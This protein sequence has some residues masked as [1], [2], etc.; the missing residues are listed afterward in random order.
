MADLM[1]S[2]P[3]ESRLTRMVAAGQ[4]IEKGIQKRL[5]TFVGLVGQMVMPLVK[6]ESHSGEEDRG[7]DGEAHPE[8]DVFSGEEVG[9]DK[10]G[11]CFFSG[12]EGGD[13]ETDIRSGDD[14]PDNGDEH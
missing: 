3:G 5:R 8:P 11:S 2:L 7:G 1:E 9:R 6:G 12:E 13:G 10:A 4:V 14:W